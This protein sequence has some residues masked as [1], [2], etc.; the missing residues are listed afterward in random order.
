MI[1]LNPTDSRPLYEQITEKLKD[2]IIGGYLKENDR[3]PSVRELA[4]GLSIN[5]NTIQKA[6]KQLEGE[7]YIYSKPAK[8]YFVNVTKE[9]N[10]RITLLATELDEVVKE[11]SFIGADKNTVMKII[12]KYFSE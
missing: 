6:Y 10:E 2:L 1:I 12:N 9:N 4:S 7:G 11:M 5:P 8:G 3:V